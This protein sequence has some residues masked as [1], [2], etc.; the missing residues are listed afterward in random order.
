[1]QNADFQKPFQSGCSLCYPSTDYYNTNQSGGKKS[2]KKNG[3]SGL[4]LGLMPQESAYGPINA[5]SFPHTNLAPYPNSTGIKTGGVNNNNSNKKTNNKH[6]N[7]LL[8][9]LNSNKK[10]NNKSNK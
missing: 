10:T 6:L 4:G 2:S 5:T 7:D 8:K 9:K 3:G 1:M